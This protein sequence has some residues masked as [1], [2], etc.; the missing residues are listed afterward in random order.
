MRPVDDDIERMLEAWAGGDAGAVDELMPLVYDELKRLARG[1]LARSP[2]SRL[3][4]DTTSLVHEAYLKF[5][6]QTRISLEGKSH[7][8]AIAARAM[9]QVLVDRARRRQTAKRGGGLPPA[10][11]DD[12]QQPIDIEVETLLA[13][14]HALVELGAESERC[15]RVVECRFFA[16]M[17]LTE[18]ARALDVSERTIER[19]WMQARGWLRRRLSP[20]QVAR[21]SAAR[22]AADGAG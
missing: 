1:Q 6:D 14:E 8:Y 19:D 5:S 9:R 2:G 15:V 7:F 11:L 13:L 22:S 20:V 18:T 21:L 17:S 3:T 4:L 10:E 12:V 16:G